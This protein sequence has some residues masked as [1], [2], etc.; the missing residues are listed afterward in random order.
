MRMRHTAI[1][2]EAPT[3][4]GSTLTELSDA[5]AG[6]RTAVVARELTKKFE[7][8]ARGTVADLAQRFTESPARGEVVILISGA[9][10]AEVSEKFLSDEAQ[11]M[12]SEGATQRQIV[13][14]LISRHGAPRNLAYKLAHQS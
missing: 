12:R 1:I 13:E 8:Y 4:V 5:G 3:R 10:P 7:E 6:A 14:W 2:Y 9:E 11:R